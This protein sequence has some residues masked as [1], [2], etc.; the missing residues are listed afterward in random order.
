MASGA[1]ILILNHPT[2]GVDV[3]AKEEIYS[4]IREI[5]A[6]GAG[7]ILLGDTLDECIGLSNRLLVMKDG[8]IT[9]EFDASPDNKPEQVDIIKYMM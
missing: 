8:E 1:D 2:R 5:V 9:H 7:A 4:L 3:G 6:K